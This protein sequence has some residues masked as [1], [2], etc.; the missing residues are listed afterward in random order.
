MLQHMNSVFNRRRGS[1]HRGG[2]LG[3]R[4][5]CG[6]HLA[7]ALL[8]REAPCGPLPI[9]GSD[10]RITRGAPS[11][12][13]NS[14]L[15]RTQRSAERRGD[16]YARL[17]I[18]SQLEE[19]LIFLRRPSLVAVPRHGDASVEPRLNSYRVALE[20]DGPLLHLGTGPRIA[21]PSRLRSF[22][23]KTTN[24]KRINQLP[25]APAFV[26]KP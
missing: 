16:Q 19:P 25:E 6:I 18:R 7:Q 9:R 20:R 15:D 2:D 10:F 22:A 21:R 14:T 8:V 24:Q 26:R 13:I 1:F 12:E 23:I 17:S 3:H 11:Y 4:C 5:T